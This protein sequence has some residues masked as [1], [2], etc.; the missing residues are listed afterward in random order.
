[1]TAFLSSLGASTLDEILESAKENSLSYQNILLEYENGLLNIAA[2]EEE[3][4]VGVSVNASVSPLVN[5]GTDEVGISI[6]PSVEVT[7]PDDG[8]TTITAD[9]SLS[10][11]YRTGKTEGSVRLGVSHIF[12]FTG[13][14]DDN[15]DNLSYTSTKYSTERSYKMN[16]LNFENTVLKMISSILR[17]ESSLESDAFNLEKQ[18]TV[19]D[20]LVALKTYSETS[21]IYLSTLNTLNSLKSS[22]EASKEQYNQLLSQYKKLTG[23]DWD[24]V[25]DVT[26]PELKLTTYENGNTEVLIQSINVEKSEDSYR[27]VA[28]MAARSDLDTSLNASL[29]SDLSFSVSGSAAYNANNWTVSVSTGVNYNKSNGS[30]TPTL[31]IS[32]RWNNDTSSS[33]RE[34]NK[35]LN[36]AKSAANSY[37]EALSEYQQSATDYALQILEWKNGLSQAETDLEY[38]KTLLDNTK[39]LYELG[40]ETEENLKKAELDYSSSWTSYTLK[41]IDGLT[42]ERNLAIFAL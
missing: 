14:T 40:L 4:K 3:D 27:K 26:A 10:T 19:F 23:L 21:S 5:S 15:A 20:K 1:M 39:A 33:D 41:V 25:E 2:L 36:D 42:L 11:R 28:A 12:D 16:Q 37:L 30:A 13:Y 7:L 8:K 18:Q 34:I 24:G 9:T 35:A 31:T 38:K 32:G 22:L 17:A 6:S 29:E